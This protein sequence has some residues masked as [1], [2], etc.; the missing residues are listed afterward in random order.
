MPVDLA[1]AEQF[2]FR[3]ARVLERHRLAALLYGAPGQPVRDALLAYR[4][5]D[6]GFGHALE[7][8]VRAPHSEP[9]STLAALEVL[10]SVPV[11]DDPLVPAAADWVGTVA[12]PDGGVPF[13]LPEAASYPR[14]PWMV[15]SDG[16]SHLTFALAAVLWELGSPGPWRERATQWCWAR[17]EH[18]AELSAYWVKFGLAFLDQ[19]EDAERAGAAIERLRSR[20]GRDGAIPVP[21]GAENER[22][23]PLALS[24]RPEGRSRRLFAPD[25]I[26]ADLDRLE[27][28]Q[29][30]DGGWTFDW[31]AWTPAQEVEWRGVVTL[32]ALT[33]LRSHRRLEPRQG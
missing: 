25:Q 23:T 28:G 1:A 19:V 22:L 13:V 30:D 3:S 15:P 6:G 4:N 18:P 14:A 11:T 31:L 5:H 16:G 8:D 9:V 24:S 10:A 7:P 17:L 32:R 29:H 2:M 26:E 33:H 20:L 21:G 12:D 27:A